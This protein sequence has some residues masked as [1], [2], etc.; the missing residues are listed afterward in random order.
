MLPLYNAKY[1]DA[2][3]FLSADSV[4]SLARDGTL[5]VVVRMQAETW[6]TID[7]TEV[8]AVN[9]ENSDIYSYSISD[10]RFSLWNGSVLAENQRM[11]F[12]VY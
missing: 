7:Y 1:P 8:F 9:P 5:L 10:N 4:I 6:D 2:K 12:K 11:N 3:F